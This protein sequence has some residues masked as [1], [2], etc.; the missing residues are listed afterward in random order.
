MKI[1]QKVAVSDTNGESTA[2]FIDAITQHRHW[3][4]S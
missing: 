2:A 1:F 3:A 4:R